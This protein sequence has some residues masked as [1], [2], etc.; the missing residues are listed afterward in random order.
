LYSEC[1][2]KEHL[3]G[4]GDLKRGAQ[5]I[6]TVKY[7]DD[8][9]LLAKEE[10][11][12]QDMIDKLIEIGGCY[13]MDIYRVSREDCKKF[14]ESVPYVKIYRYNPKHLYPNLNGYGDNG[15]RSLKL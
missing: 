15:Q 13:G 1:L 11:V 7:A 10:K 5:I 3:E 4:F 12:L 14:R 8:L 2:T 6:H 9:V